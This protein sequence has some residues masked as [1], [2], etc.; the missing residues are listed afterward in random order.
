MKVIYWVI[1]VWYGGKDR[2]IQ[3][4]ILTR[5]QRLKST[6]FFEEKWKFIFYAC[7]NRY[8]KSWFKKNLV[9]QHELIGS[10]LF[11]SILYWYFKNYFSQ[12]NSTV[13]TL[14]RFRLKLLFKLFLVS[15]HHKS[16]FRLQFSRTSKPFST[17]K[18]SST[19]V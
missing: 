14:N 15:F 7:L 12:M 18:I 5:Y 3:L 9:L 4:E 1:D 16:I 19:K 2:K 17:V 10:I 13:I 8:R 11:S 6:R